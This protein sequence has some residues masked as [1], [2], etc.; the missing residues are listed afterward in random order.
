M[1]NPRQNRI[2]RS[3]T[4]VNLEKL[5]LTKY[6]FFNAL[7]I[8]TLPQNFLGCCR[9]VHMLSRHLLRCVFNSRQNRINR[10]PTIINLENIFFSKNNFFYVLCIITR[11]QNLMGYCRVVCMLSRHFSRCV[12]NSRRNRIN[13]SPT[14]TNLKKV[15]FLKIYSPWEPC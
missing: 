9:V 11:P 4:I 2:N 10:F 14:I 5:L 7:C 13:R 3:P 12:F 8:I 6:N 1:F 15:F